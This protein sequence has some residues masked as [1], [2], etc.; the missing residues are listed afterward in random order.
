LAHPEGTPLSGEVPYANQDLLI[1]SVK[2]TLEA[3]KKVAG[4]APKILVIGAV[5]DALIFL[6]SSS[7]CVLMFL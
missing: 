5:S 4:R 6:K 2:E 7:S 1:E 3:G